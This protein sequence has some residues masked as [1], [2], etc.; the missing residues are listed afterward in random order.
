M[1]KVNCKALEIPEATWTLTV[2]QLQIYSKQ[3]QWHIYCRQALVPYLTT[4]LKTFSYYPQVS[5][6]SF[7]FFN[8]FSVAGI[9]VTNPSCKE[10]KCI[11]MDLTKIKYMC[12]TLQWFRWR[13]WFYDTST[14][15]E[16]TKSTT[17]W[18]QCLPIYRDYLTSEKVTVS[19]GHNQYQT[20]AT[21]TTVCKCE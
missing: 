16:K 17:S 3:F 15:T 4:I 2:N 5:L 8:E 1:P 13:F 10:T 18:C 6:D 9:I 12:T 20:L 14:K 7:P 11:T 21:M 19:Q